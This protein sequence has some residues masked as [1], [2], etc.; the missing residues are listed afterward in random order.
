MIHI[1]YQRDK[2]NTLMAITPLHEYEGY[3]YQVTHTEHLIAITAISSK[4]LYH[5]LQFLQVKRATVFLLLLVLNSFPAI[6][7]III[8]ENEFVE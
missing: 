1:V 8:S 5:I 3:S 4:L 6:I 7:V 2:N